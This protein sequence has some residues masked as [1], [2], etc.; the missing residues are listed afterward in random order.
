[1]TYLPYPKFY[2][3][4]YRKLPCKASPFFCFKTW[5]SYWY[6]KMTVTQTDLCLFCLKIYILFSSSIISMQSSK[7]GISTTS[8]FHSFTN[9][10]PWILVFNRLGIHTLYSI[11]PIPA[12]VEGHITFYLDKWNSILKNWLLFSLK[13]LKLFLCSI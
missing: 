3:C 7:T 10:V 9:W 11:L 1:M 6:L 8:F 13:D 12:A 5:E 4:D 2:N